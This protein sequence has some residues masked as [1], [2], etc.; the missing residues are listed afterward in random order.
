MVLDFWFVY[1]SFH[2]AFNRVL[3]FFEDVMHGV[4]AGRLRVWGK[5][6][7]CTPALQ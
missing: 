7:S 6:V 5:T 2:L 1:R 3:R 4:W